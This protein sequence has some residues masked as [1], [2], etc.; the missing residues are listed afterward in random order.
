MIT[1]KM[2]DQKPPFKK[3]RDLTRDWKVARL[4]T[5]RELYLRGEPELNCLRTNA[6]L[7][8]PIQMRCRVLSSETC[9]QLWGLGE[10]EEHLCITLSTAHVPQRLRLLP[11]A[12]SLTFGRLY[13]LVFLWVR[14]NEGLSLVPTKGR[15]PRVKQSS[16]RLELWRAL[17]WNGGTDYCALA[18]H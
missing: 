18:S 5:G 13:I 1:T 11:W 16:S 4:S 2:P 9:L 3:F 14:G 15:N 6:H 17:F 8:A 10:E 7:E 12:H